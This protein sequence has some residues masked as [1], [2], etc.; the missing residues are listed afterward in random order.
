MTS[1]CTLSTGSPE[2][3][4]WSTSPS[5]PRLFVGAKGLAL[6]ASQYGDF[7]APIVLLLHGGRVMPGPIRLALSPER[8]TV[9]SLWMR[10]GTAKAIGVHKVTT[11]PKAWSQTSTL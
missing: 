11:A 5:T 2:Q 1:S 10:A 9:P 3:K 4:N 7:T 6:R 8:A